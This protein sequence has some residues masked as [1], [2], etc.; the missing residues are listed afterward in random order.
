LDHSL[1]Q[2]LKPD[3]DLPGFIGTTKVMPC[4]KA[5]GNCRCDEFFRSL[6]SPRGNVFSTLC[7]PSAAKAVPFQ[8]RSIH[9]SAEFL[10]RFLGCRPPGLKAGPFLGAAGARAIGEKYG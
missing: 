5:I 1:L 2:G 6:F 9:H 3:I 8:S 4:Y 10:Y 7:I